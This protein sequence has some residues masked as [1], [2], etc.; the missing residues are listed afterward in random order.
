[1]NNKLT[2]ERKADNEQRL[3]DIEQH[4]QD[5]LITRE[6]ADEKIRQIMAS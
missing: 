3:A 4:V 5:G 1:M 6:E 2:A